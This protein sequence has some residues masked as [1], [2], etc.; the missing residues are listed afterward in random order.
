MC[1]QTFM[2]FEKGADV[3]ISCVFLRMV[4]ILL[5]A[6]DRMR[7]YP[8]EEMGFCLNIATLRGSPGSWP[9]RVRSDW[10]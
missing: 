10:G 5:T 8:L 6:R 2:L 3:G 7:L 9:D 4:S 1:V